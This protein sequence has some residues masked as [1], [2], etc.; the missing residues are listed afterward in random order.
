MPTVTQWQ[1]ALSSNYQ[2]KIESSLDLCTDVLER[3]RLRDQERRAFGRGPVSTKDLIPWPNTGRQQTVL[4]RPIDMLHALGQ[5]TTPP[6]TELID[7]SSTWAEIRYLWAFRPNFDSRH[8]RSLRLSP[9]VKELDFHQK[10]L[11]SDEFGVG[12]AAY[13]MATFEQ[14][15]DPVDAFIAKRRGQVRVRGSSRRSLPDYIFR[16]PQENQYYVVECKGTQGG[17]STVVGQ[18]QRGSEQVLTVDIAPPASV[19]RLVIGAWLQQSI[20]IF[21]IDP[22][23]EYEV[24][25]LS[26]WSSEE[27]SRFAN[28]K[29]LTY[30]GDTIG[31]SELLRGLVN[32]EQP[33]ILETPEIVSRRTELGVFVGSD[34]VRRT[35]D[36]RRVQMFRGM[37]SDLYKD[38]VHNHGVEHRRREVAKIQERI[39][40]FFLETATDDGTAVVRSI[41]RD[42]SM[43]EVQIS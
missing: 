26:R 11:M 30:I 18:L 19:I 32:Q 3:Q 36:G 7:L 9:S 27:I 2:I 24:P 34:Q 35:P 1:Q 17:K 5:I 31:A 37:R 4:I 13:Y 22:D 43:F 38:M 12:F 39:D 33:L 15:T 8:N 20:T 28:A 23:D 16:G 40:A 29:R 42:G 14:T 21:V 10:T 41:S 25:K 6:V